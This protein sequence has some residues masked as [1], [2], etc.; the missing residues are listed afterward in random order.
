MALAAG[1]ALTGVGTRAGV[2]AEL[3]AKAM[4]VVSESLHAGRKT[5]R[6]RDNVSF[7]IPFHL[8]AV[9]YHHVLVAGVSHAGCNHCIGHVPDEGF[10]D[11][12]AKLVPAVPSH[13]RGGGKAAVKGIGEGLRLFL[14]RK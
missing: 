7:G 3:E 4:D 5:L 9:V 10:G 11:V 2:H 8:P 6:V 12:A 13:G 1:T 14:G